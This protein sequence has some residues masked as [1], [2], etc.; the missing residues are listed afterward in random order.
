[1]KYTLKKPIKI[2]PDLMRSYEELLQLNQLVTKKIFEIDLLMRSEF[3]HQV[4]MTEQRHEFE[5]LN[6]SVNE[7]L[8][9]FERKHSAFDEE[10]GV[11]VRFLG[12]YNN[13]VYRMQQYYEK[14]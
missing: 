3:K 13:T 12:E 1:M 10:R 2:A 9:G 6:Q 5:Y 11:F 7:Y 4:S 8:S 14:E